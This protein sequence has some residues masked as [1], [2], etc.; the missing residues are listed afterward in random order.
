[1][2]D[3]SFAPRHE[4]SVDSLGAR[5]RTSAGS[6]SER[7]SSVHWLRGGTGSASTRAMPLLQFPDL[8]G[9]SA[10]MQGL[11]SKALS[12]ADAG[13]PILITGKVGSGKSALARALHRISSRSTGSLRVMRSVA[14][15]DFL[16]TGEEADLLTRARHPAIT[17]RF[18]HLVTTGTLILDEVGDLPFGAQTALARL[19]MS[20]SGPA[21]VIALSHMDLQRAVFEGRFRSDLLCA[22]SRGRL[23]MPSLSERLDDLK[24]L[25]AWFRD[26][27]APVHGPAADFSDAAF[28]AM[29]RHPWPGN[30]RELRNRIERAMLVTRTPWVQAADL[31]LTV[32]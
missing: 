21:N 15:P 8:I 17:A 27:L 10:P 6:T 3:H 22:L 24:P 19:L 25:A 13:H 7:H 20:Q 29:H 30:V 4:P 1:M 11:Y 16:A 9:D 5:T 31:G 32:G 23:E 18:G 28:R 14:F 26:R 2:R 12:L